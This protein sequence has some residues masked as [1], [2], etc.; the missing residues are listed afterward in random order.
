MLM[1]IYLYGV[2]RLTQ[3]LSNFYENCIPFL[4]IHFFGFPFLVTKLKYIQYTYI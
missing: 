3:G 2:I 4:Q 1:H